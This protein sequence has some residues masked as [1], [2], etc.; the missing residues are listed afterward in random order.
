[1]SGNSWFSLSSKE[2][3]V[4][5]LLGQGVSTAEIASRMD[6]SPRTVESCFARIR[7]KLGLSGMKELKNQ[8]V[9]KPI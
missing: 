2:Q 6:L 8:A 4:Y 3:H 5:K 9:A 1:M 7:I